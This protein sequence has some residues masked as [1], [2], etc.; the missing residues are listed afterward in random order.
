MCCT[1]EFFGLTH[2]ADMHTI[3]YFVMLAISA[4]S[5]TFIAQV[6]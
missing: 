2:A 1:T 4:G 3:N 6:D 5:S